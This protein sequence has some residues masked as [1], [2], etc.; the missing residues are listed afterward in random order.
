FWQ[1]YPASLEVRKTT[2]DAADLCIWLWSPDA[3]AMDLRHYDTRAHD[4]DSSYEDV[5]PGFSTAH[6]IART[7]EMTLF[8]SAGIVAKEDVV[9][10][11]SLAQS[12][13]L[14]VATAEHLHS[15]SVF[16]IWS[17]PDRSTAAK[18]SMED[19]LDAAF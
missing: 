17:L 5:Q 1:S 12:P 19:L 6:G 3:A 10:Q 18:R 13:P 2:S 15:T 14:L 4:L 9:K 11:A 8:P 7:S 16:G